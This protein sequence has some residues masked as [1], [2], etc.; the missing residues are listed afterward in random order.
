[1]QKVYGI[2]CV[3]LIHLS[4]VM[5]LCEICGTV[6][7]PKFFKNIYFLEAWK[8]S[9]SG[10]C[11]K[12]PIF[13]LIEHCLFV[14]STSNHHFSYIHLFLSTWNGILHLVHCFHSFFYFWQKLN[15]LFALRS[16]TITL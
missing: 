10:E 11:W 4:L 3:T 9:M 1:V 6:T 8:L 16:R 2:T 5:R 12:L 7:L 14:P 15:L 13:C